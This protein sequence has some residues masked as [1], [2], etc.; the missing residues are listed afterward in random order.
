MRASAGATA[1]KTR[2]R[3]AQQIL[4][5]IRGQDRGRLTSP[6][7]KAQVFA[8]VDELRAQPQQQSFTEASL[9]SATWQLLWTSEQ[10]TLWILNNAGLF[11]TKAGDVFQVIDVPTSRLQVLPWGVSQLGSVRGWPAVLP[12]QSLG[13]ASVGP[14]IAECAD[15][16]HRM[17]PR[18]ATRPCTQ[19]VITFP[20]EGAFV[21]DSSIHV[22]GPQRVGFKFSAAKLQLPQNRVI[23]VPPFG[24]GW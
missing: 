12:R 4:E 8:L 19:N 14:A 1:P 23:P 7:Q 20:P 21:V 9:L 17:R 2:P 18:A 5:L 11:G 10:E 3:Q 6:Q 15:S 13:H 22:D 16:H 24:Q